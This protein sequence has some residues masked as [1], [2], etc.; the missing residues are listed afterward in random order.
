MGGSGPITL[1]VTNWVNKSTAGQRKVPLGKKLAT[2]L[3]GPAETL[4]DQHGWTRLATS[5]TGPAESL[6]TRLTGPAKQ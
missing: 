5:L 2:S 6:V 4:D 3:S 1:T